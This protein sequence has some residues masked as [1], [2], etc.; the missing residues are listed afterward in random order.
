MA[1]GNEALV[2]VEQDLGTILRLLSCWECCKVSERNQVV[3][4]GVRR[5]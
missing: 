3:F 2:F 1:V 5:M 4:E